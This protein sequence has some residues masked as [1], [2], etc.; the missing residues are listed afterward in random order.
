[1]SSFSP[2]FLYLYHQYTKHLLSTLLL[3]R[4]V[5]LKSKTETPYSTLLSFQYLHEN[6]M[7]ELK[8]SSFTSIGNFIFIW[9]NYI[10]YTKMLFL[11]WL[12]KLPKEHHMIN[13]WAID[14]YFLRFI[15]VYL[16]NTL[17]VTDLPA[18]HVGWK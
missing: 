17:S 8:N 16:I 9:Y 1:M 4:A 12:Y 7:N 10:K 15:N 2:S 13:K 11:K 18:F 6:Q 5:D 14:S 3:P